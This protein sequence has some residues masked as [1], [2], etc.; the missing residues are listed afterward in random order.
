[1]SSIVRSTL[2]AAALATSA[3]PAARGQSVTQ[4]LAS[5]S[6]DVDVVYPTRAGVCG[7]GRGSIS[8]V[9][10]DDMQSGN[11][12]TG[13]YRNSY[14]RPCVAGPARVA[15]S[16]DAGQ[17]T[18][19][20][21]YVGPTPSSTSATRT[22]NVSAAE[23]ATWLSGVVEHADGRIASDA[24]VALLVADAPEPWPL[25]LR[26]A[27]DQDRSRATRSAALF[28]LGNGANAK[29]GLNRDRDA[30]D[31]DQVRE[32]VVFALSQRPKSESVPE[33]MDLARHGKYPS[34]RRSA[35]FWLGQT[36]DPR[37]ADVYADLLG[38]H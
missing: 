13:D 9:L 18:R 19:L 27:R 36:G 29:L 25:L 30:S 6:G 34:V 2:V 22:L 33:L 31:E 12:T 35:I 32:Q 26:V 17:V 8:H 20:R 23:A 10:G 16:M 11:I 38:V 24:I 15:V 1:M 4:R 3:V 28:W 37:A 21:V 14:D 7:D 5:S